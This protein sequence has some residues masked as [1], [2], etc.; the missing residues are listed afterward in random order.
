MRILGLDPGSVATGYG[1]VERRGSRLVHVAHGTLRPPRG[2]VL[3]D[4]LAF[5]HREIAR[6]VAEHAP[7]LAAVERCFAGRSVR[8][9][10]VLGQA[11]GVALAAI[12][13]GGVPIT[14][15]APQHVKLA[16]TGNGNAEKV[17]VQAMVR[18]LL[19]LAA[20]P[21]KD[22]AD[23]LAAAI[24]IAFRGRLGS[25]STHDSAPR[26]RTAARRHESGGI[27]L[28]LVASRA[29]ARTSRL[30]VRTVR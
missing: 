3:P 21:P 18:R 14:E 5:L 25:L 19:A 20:A 15:L 4:R 24:A 17:Q 22:A 16:V 8:S 27:E 7:V 6:I 26:P 9:A 13:A 12:A 1:V 2:S 29:R 30:I 10:L 23:A 11:R 28:G